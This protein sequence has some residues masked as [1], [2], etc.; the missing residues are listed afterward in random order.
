MMLTTLFAKFNDRL[1]FSLIE[2]AKIAK[3]SV[4][5]IKYE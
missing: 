2:I 1:S 5:E 3:L 4:H